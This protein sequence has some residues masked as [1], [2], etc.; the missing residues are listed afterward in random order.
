M[1]LVLTLTVDLPVEEG[2]DI[3]RDIDPRT[4]KVVIGD[5]EGSIRN[6]QMW[7][8]S[9]KRTKKKKEAA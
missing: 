2:F 9:G 1:K 4:L 6:C 5:R 7:L 3:R 8:S